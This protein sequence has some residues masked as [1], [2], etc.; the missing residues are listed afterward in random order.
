[1]VWTCTED[2][3]WINSAKDVE[4]GAARQQQKRRFMDVVREDI[5]RRWMGQMINF[6]DP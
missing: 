4:Y 5:Q 2:G 1:M 3:Q 6:S